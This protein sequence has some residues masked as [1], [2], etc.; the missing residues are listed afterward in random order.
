VPSSRCRVTRSRA[1]KRCDRGVGALV[2]VALGCAA[3]SGAGISAPPPSFA[4]S[5]SPDGGAPARR[6][7]GVVLEPPPAMPVAAGA[8]S[9]RGV[10]AL[11]EPVS[12]DAVVRVVEA[13]VEAWQRE[14]LDG[15]LALVTPDAQSLDARG[16]PGTALAEGWRQR[17][18]AHE[19]K[20]LAGIELVRPE[21]IR[22][23]DYDDLGAKGAPA[24]PLEMRPGDLLVRV[25]F[26]VTHAA[27]EK[28]FGDFLVLVLR[29][30]GAAL[31]VAAYGEE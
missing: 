3:C 2:G 9:A 10:V 6:P 15:L 12:D 22:R 13:L 23:W 29:P 26:E 11:R 19:Y 21:Q 5:L 24:R 28:L 7:D 31:R 30:S 1:S 25:P 8:A 17:L 18:Q 20:R 4:E 27:G 14:S 16:H